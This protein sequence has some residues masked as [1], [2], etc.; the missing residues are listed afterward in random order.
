MLIICII[1]NMC[2]LTTFCDVIQILLK[3]KRACQNL[4]NPIYQTSFKF[5]H[6]LKQIALYL[7]DIKLFSLRSQ[8]WF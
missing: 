8:I 2:L 7:D 3:D 1:N 5:F 4:F 6:F